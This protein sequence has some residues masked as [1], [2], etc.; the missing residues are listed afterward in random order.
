MTR[1]VYRIPDFCDPDTGSVYSDIEFI[2]ESNA[3]DI[4][5]TARLAGKIENA[6]SPASP[7]NCGDLKV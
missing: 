2:V 6:I 4:R 3:D 1:V 5:E 7:P